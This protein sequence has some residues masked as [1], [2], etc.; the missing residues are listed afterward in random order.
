MK[1]YLI[2]V[3]EQRVVAFTVKADSEEEAIETVLNGEYS[4]V[5]YLPADLDLDSN[6]WN[7]EEI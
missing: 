6:N 5:E 7:I 4:G 3:V 1:T 2:E